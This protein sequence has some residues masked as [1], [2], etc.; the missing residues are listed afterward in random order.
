M[1]C[2]KLF[3]VF[4][5]L[6]SGVYKRFTFGPISPEQDLISDL[7]RLTKSVYHLQKLID[8]IVES[9]HLLFFFITHQHSG[10]LKNST[11]VLYAQTY[12]VALVFFDVHHCF[13]LKN[14]GHPTLNDEAYNAERHVKTG[15][16]YKSLIIDLMSCGVQIE[17]CGA[18][19]A[20]Y[21]W[22]NADLIP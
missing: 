18:T 4:Y 11:F 12:K 5:E 2:H 17:L 15:N 3:L 21:R 6:F 19:A 14:A 20:V 16:P 7:A 9:R 10:L 13:N 8:L 1:P 22:G